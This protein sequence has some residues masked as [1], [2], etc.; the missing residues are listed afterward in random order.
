[1]PQTRF[2]RTPRITTAYQKIA[3]IAMIENDDKQLRKFEIMGNNRRIS[4]NLNIPSIILKL[5]D[6]D[7]LMSLI[8]GER[9]TLLAIFKIFKVF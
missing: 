6:E 7:K 1:M 3:L 8:Y 9:W 5:D 2:K 4:P